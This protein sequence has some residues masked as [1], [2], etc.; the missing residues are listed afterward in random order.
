MLI[1]THLWFGELEEGEEWYKKGKETA[2]INTSDGYMI[3]RITNAAVLLAEHERLNLAFKTMDLAL[4]LEPD[5]AGLYDQIGGL[6]LK[7]A[8]EFFDKAL[9]KDAS[10]Q[11]S[12]EMIKKLEDM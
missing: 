2:S 6:Y 3:S 4:K 7:R 5:N 1:E 8:R 9:E 12:R 11:R 10:R